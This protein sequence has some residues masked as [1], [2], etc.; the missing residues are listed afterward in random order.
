MT[1]QPLNVLDIMA[2]ATGAPDESAQANQPSQAEQ[3]E[4]IMRLP[5]LPNPGSQRG[6]V[7][8]AAAN[9]ALQ[10]MHQLG[11]GAMNGTVGECGYPV[12]IATA[13]Y[14]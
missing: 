2:A 1:A 6:P 11:A 9:N 4:R 8:A 7:A 3:T 10:A 14:G 12:H 13:S 5:S